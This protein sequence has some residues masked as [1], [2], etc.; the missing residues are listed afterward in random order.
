MSKHK[1]Q[2]KDKKKASQL[3]IR[4]E[5]A[6]RDAFVALCNRLDT[7][8]AREIRRFMRERV[9]EH[10]VDAA[11][12]TGMPPVADAFD[13][14]PAIAEAAPALTLAATDVVSDAPAVET[15]KPQKKQKRAAP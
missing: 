1:T 4:V 6:E 15:E 12:E 3:V 9:T 14:A 7:S 10:T 2:G 5:K 8:A 11:G 13:G